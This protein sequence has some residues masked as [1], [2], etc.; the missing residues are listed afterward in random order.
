MSQPNSRRAF[1]LTLAG[2][3]GMVGSM[4]TAPAA[5]AET[6]S[7]AQT[8]I[9]EAL[10]RRR[11]RPSQKATTPA[12]NDEQ[13]ATVGAL[14]AAIV[15]AD[16]TPSARDL[17][18]HLYAAAGLALVPPA[19]FAAIQAGLDT[20]AAMA[21]QTF[22]VP[23][24][25]LPPE[26]LEALAAALVAQPAIAPLWNAVRTLTVLF[27]YSQPQGFADLGLPGPSIDRGG[28]PDPTNLPCL[29]LAA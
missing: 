12:L 7:A 16:A 2:L 29:S 19:D 5:G 24:G 14:A 26:A 23:I 22:G 9:N 15:P 17:G 13:V 1:V 4:A 6:V 28:F 10:G 25:Q 27:Y 8:A 3:A 18:A 11:D 20:V 21:L